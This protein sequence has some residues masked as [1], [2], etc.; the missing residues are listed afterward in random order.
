MTAILTGTTLPDLDEL[1]EFI[2]IPA[3]VLS[4][5][6]L[7]RSFKAAIEHVADTCRGVPVADG[8]VVREEWP[9]RLVEAVLR[10]VQRA[11]A[12]KNLPLGYLDNAGE[13]GPAK[14]P[15]YDSRIEELEGSFR[16]FVFGGRGRS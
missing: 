13:Y 7:D 10:R 11:I 4:D 3:A 8:Q 6:D 2:A 5:D 9:A 15:T 12:A 1:R 14:I 16:R